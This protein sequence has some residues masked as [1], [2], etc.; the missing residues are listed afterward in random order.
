M[1]N[2][3]S[4]HEGL[5]FSNLQLFPGHQ[6]SQKA[7]PYF[8]FCLPCSNKTLLWT[9]SYPNE[10]NPSF[11]VPAFV[12]VS[13][14]QVKHHPFVMRNTKYPL[15]LQPLFCCGYLV[16]N[17]CATTD[18]VEQYQTLLGT[19]HRN[20]KAISTY[21]ICRKEAL[22]LSANSFASKMLHLTLH[23]GKKRFLSEWV[24]LTRWQKR[25][26]IHIFS[27]VKSAVTAVRHSML[28]HL[29]SFSWI[30]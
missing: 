13:C 5:F 21:A 6:V 28:W 11:R 16:K 15:D 7:L 10:Q 27:R 1:K 25:K 9:Y 12:T 23:L 19:F 3:Y 26:S 17:K 8:Y 4:L 14:R 24:L 22:S 20:R 2:S 29:L 18:A 30:I